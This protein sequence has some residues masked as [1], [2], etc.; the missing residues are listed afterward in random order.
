[1]IMNISLIKHLSNFRLSL[2]VKKY[3]PINIED[4]DDY[5]KSTPRSVYINNRNRIV[6]NINKLND[7]LDILAHLNGINT[8]G[9]NP[10][11]FAHSNQMTIITLS[12]VIRFFTKV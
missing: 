6:E 7:M 11:N 3:N 2:A 5:L 12:D 4:D 10:G 1:M 9:H 8:D